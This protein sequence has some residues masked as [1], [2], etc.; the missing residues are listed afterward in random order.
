MSFAAGTLNGLAMWLFFDYIPPE[1]KLLIFFSIVGLIAA[2]SGTH[3][4]DLPTFWLFL[5][6]S[7]LLAVAKLIFCGER[8]YLALS[9]M[10]ILYIL[11]MVRVGRQ[12]HTTLQ[13]N[14]RLTHTMHYRATHD[15]LVGLLN[16]AEFENQFK[17]R[18][19]GTSHSVAMLFL[20][21]DN[22]KPLNDTLGHQAGDNA[23]KQVADILL[24]AFRKD[25]VIARLGGDEFVVLLLLDDVTQAEKIALKVLGDI[26]AISFPG[27]HDYTGL[28]ASIG[29]AFSHDKDILFSRLMQVADTACY[30]SKEKG[31]N[32]ITISSVDKSGL[33]P[34]FASGLQD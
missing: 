14:F 2:A 15:P 22:F 5:Y 28:T 24:N 20:D 6:P 26:K 27:R 16:R 21:L 30:Q 19:A 23:L 25:D 10:F 33:S 31:K 34:A 18:L 13:Q 1:Y 8:A 3:G 17:I 11:V 9:L 12:N 4:V 32:Q 29:I 7:C